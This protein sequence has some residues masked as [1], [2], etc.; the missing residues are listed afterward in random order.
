MLSSSLLSSS[1]VTRD[2][3]GV[4]GTCTLGG[5]ASDGETSGGGGGAAGASVGA[6]DASRYLAAAAAAA[7]PRRLDARRTGTGAATGASSEDAATGEGA[8]AGAASTADAESACVKPPNA[9]PR[10]GPRAAIAT[11]AAS[12][13]DGVVPEPEPEPPKSTRER[14]G[15]KG[16]G[17]GVGV[18][19]ISPPPSLEEVVVV[20][21]AAAIPARP[22][23]PPT[24]PGLV[25]LLR[26]ICFPSF[27]ATFVLAGFDWIEGSLD[28][29]LRDAAKDMALS[30]TP[31]P[32][33]ALP[34]LPMN[35]PEPD[36]AEPAMEPP[37]ES[38]LRLRLRLSSG[39][40]SLPSLPASGALLISR[41]FVLA[42]IALDCNLNLSSSSRSTLPMFSDIFGACAM[43]LIRFA[44]LAVRYA[45]PFKG[46]AILS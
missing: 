46:V 34:A 12:A 27:E 25:S 39:F 30:A 9:L 1:M 38:R 5:G 7:I 33:A 28:A 22:P 43:P 29:I 40:S 11:G 20:A 45:P 3:T 17:M 26:A 13:G 35:V 36:S 23:I 37:R 31:P 44:R 8:T 18:A 2:L 14:F 6:G 32:A 10:R 16:K 21:A 41:I 42:L 19:E 15:P 24:P 4:V